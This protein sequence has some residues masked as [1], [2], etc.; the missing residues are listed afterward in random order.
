MTF[1]AYRDNLKR[2]RVVVVMVLLCP[3]GAVRTWQCFCRWHF[4]LGDSIGYCQASLSFF[5]P[6]SMVPNLLSFI[7]GLASGGMVVAFICFILYRPTCFTLPVCSVYCRTVFA[8]VICKASRSFADITLVL[9]AR[10]IGTVLR[11][12]RDTL[13]YLAMRASFC[14]NC[15]RHSFTSIKVMFTPRAA[16]SACGFFIV[17]PH[18]VIA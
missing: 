5:G 8:V 11:K 1:N 15:L 18:L 7:I 13:N 17:H 9:K 16:Q 4:T 12:L 14:L 10:W 6:L 3:I 2:L